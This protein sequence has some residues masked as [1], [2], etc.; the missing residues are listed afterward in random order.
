MLHK[1]L[2]EWCYPGLYE[3]YCCATNRSYFGQSENVLYRLG[4]HYNDLET[5]KNH[6]V[7]ELQAD[8]ETYGR[9]S[10]EF[11]P[12]EIGPD[13]AEKKKRIRKE[14]YYFSVNAGRLYNNYP[15]TSVNYRKECTID[16][17]TYSSGAEAARNL[18]WSAST[19]Y[20]YLKQLEKNENSSK[21]SGASKYIG[22]QKRVSIQG[23]E[24]SSITQ[25]INTL[26]VAKSTLYRRLKSPKYPE[27]F[28]IE[29]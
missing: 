2:L 10:F 4:R 24:F 18:G 22:A 20:R 28:Y 21:S 8:W 26:G 17:V 19:L 14:Q 7:P 1:N 5:N 27:W 9:T 25:A 6:E 29:N 15:S 16:G 13:W 3:I 23:Q 11:R 12:L